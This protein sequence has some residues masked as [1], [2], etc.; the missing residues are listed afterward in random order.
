MAGGIKSREL[1]WQ[2]RNFGL[3]VSWLSES[4]TTVHPAARGETAA[5]WTPPSQPAAR[6]PVEAIFL[7]ESAVTVWKVWIRKSKWKQM[8]AK[9]LSFIF[10]RLL[11]FAANSR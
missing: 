7:F 5:V 10:T 4:K 6:T 2:S 11:L 1:S 9:L 8:K 3:M